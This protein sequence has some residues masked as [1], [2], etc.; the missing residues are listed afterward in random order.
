MDCIRLL[1]ISLPYDSSVIHVHLR[2]KAYRTFR[3]KKH[4]VVVTVQFFI[5]YTVTNTV[6]KV[7]IKRVHSV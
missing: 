6:F 5:Y 4:I 1:T 7:Y 3:E 2:H